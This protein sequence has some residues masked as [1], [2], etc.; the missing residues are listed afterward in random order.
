VKLLE[1]VVIIDTVIPIL[2]PIFFISF[3]L[4][5]IRIVKGPTI[6]DMVLA[7]DCLGF[8][9]ALLMALL[10]LYYRSPFLIV[11]ALLLVLWTFILDLYVAKYLE[12]RELGE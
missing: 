9:L 8:D 1:P 11:G 3:I 5:I 6:P 2:I 7:V 10:T 12:K 4:Y